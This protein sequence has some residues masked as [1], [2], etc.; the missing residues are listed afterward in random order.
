V[1]LIFR[2]ASGFL[3]ALYHTRWEKQASE[4]D[5]STVFYTKAVGRRNPSGTAH[6]RPFDV[7]E[8]WSGRFEPVPRHRSEIEDVDN[9]VLGEEPSPA[10]YAMVMSVLQLQ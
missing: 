6:Y 9:A 8:L 5:F 2:S 3:L 10:I 7:P 4:P 1:K